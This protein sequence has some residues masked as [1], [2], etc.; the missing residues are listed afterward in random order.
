[1]KKIRVGVLFGGKSAEHEV[2]LLSADHVVAALDK[3][4]YEVVLIGIDKSGKWRLCDS[5]QF[6]IDRN[7]PRK[8]Q[9]Q[10]TSQEMVLVPEDNASLVS[11]NEK[12]SIPF[13]VIFPV[14]HG[15]NGEDGTMQGLLKLANIPFVGAGVLGSA[16]GMDK[17]VMKRLLKEAGVAI[18]RFI[19]LRKGD[20]CSFEEISQQLGLP[21]FIKPANAGSSVGVHKVKN[22][23][24]FDGAIRDAFKYD[25]KIL[26]EEFIRGMEVECAVIGNE[27]PIASIP[28]E[29][30][31][32]DHEFHTYAAKYYEDGVHFRIP[33]N[34]S[35]E[36]IREVQEISIKAYKALYCEGGARVDLFLKDNLV[37]VVNEINTIPGFTRT[38]A[39]PKL[40]EQ[41]GIPFAEVVDRLI[42]Y[43]MERFKKDQ[44]LQFS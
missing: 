41:S 18:A 29:V 7:N 32:G 20:T 3:D 39:F 30:I 15:T 4:K 24:E 23:S 25:R 21:F 34:L 44:D 6:L 22:A 10:S 43:A 14:L 27:N 8:V 36:L 40:W 12:T 2:S 28:G 19:C 38:S 11:L 35:Q 26:C 5:E 9:L 37:P 17:E 42:E 13:D 33:P 1:M 31:L 16:V